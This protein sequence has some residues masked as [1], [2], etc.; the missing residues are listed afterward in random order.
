MQPENKMGNMPVD[1]LL[2]TMSLPMMISML[3]QALY[4]IVDSIFVSR[5]NEYALRAVS[6]AFPIQ[7]L[8]IAVAV[9]TGVGINA[10]LSRTLGEKDFKKANTIAVNGIFI[11]L[12]SYVIFVLVGIFVSRPFFASQTVIPEVREYGVVYLTVC[13]CASIGIFMQITF[14][15]LLQSTGRTM[16]TM[17]TQG[18]GAV[19]NLILDPIL[20]FGLFGLPGLGVAGAAAA[21]VIGQIAAAVLAVVLNLKANRELHISFRGFRPDMGLIGNIYKVGVPSIV[22]QAIGSVMTY[23]MNLI[24]EA[25]GAAQTVFGVYFKLQ[26]FIFMPIFGLNNGMVPIIAY[27]FGAGSRERVVKTIKSS[28]AYAVGIML[29][30]LAV[31]EAFPAQL[32]GLFNA[33]PELLEIG[34]PALRIICLSFCFAGYCIVVGSVFQALGNGVYSMIVSIARQLCVLLPVAWL[35][36]LSGNVDLIWWSFPIAELVSLGLSTFFLIRIDRNVIRR[37]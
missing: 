23:G 16:Y 8:M 31:M 14:E 1:R 28:I 19:I 26:S 6:L 37:I 21:T 36:S 4:N 24:L 25:F 20:I 13:C 34:V 15:R 27:N 9:G 3:V 29:V 2:I 18:V 30:G 10:F 12:V 35:F 33:S 11:E 17:V 5:I 7:S 22:M 32:I